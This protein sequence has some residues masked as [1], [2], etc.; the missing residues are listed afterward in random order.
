MDVFAALIAP[1]VPDLG[2]DNIAQAEDMED[3]VLVDEDHPWH[4]SGGC[5]TAVSDRIATSKHAKILD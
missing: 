1:A 4:F 5:T 3:V 2:D